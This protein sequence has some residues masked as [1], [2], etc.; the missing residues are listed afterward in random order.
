MEGYVD[1]SLWETDSYH[2][3]VNLP[4]SWPR[5]V[6]ELLPLPCE[7]YPPPNPQHAP[8]G[9]PGPGTFLKTLIV[10]C[11]T[12]DSGFEAFGNFFGAPSQQA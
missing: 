1:Y 2:S 4:T 7:I 5:M 3:V 12:F 11:F 8:H 6:Q 10:N 9:T